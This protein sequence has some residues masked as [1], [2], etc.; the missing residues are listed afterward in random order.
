M[1]TWDVIQ[2][3]AGHQHNSG[4]PTG[5]RTGGFIFLSAIRGVDPETQKPV[6]G[7][8]AQAIQAFENARVALDAAGAGLADIVKVGVYMI[9]LQRDR[10][11][12]NK[13]WH[14]HFPDASPARFAVEVTDMGARDDATLFLLDIT[15]V[16][17][18]H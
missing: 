11:V 6:E 4:T 8:E 14:A 15:A 5:A 3:K 1:G 10:P 7:A 12:F 18:A 9:D 2:T 17:P 13:V 16:A